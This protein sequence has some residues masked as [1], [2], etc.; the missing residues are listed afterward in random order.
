MIHQ[1]HRILDRPGAVAVLHGRPLDH[2]DGQA[3]MAGGGDFCRGGLATG[4]LADDDVDAMIPQE[5]DFRL[6]REG[7]PRKQVADIG[8]I[9]R[10]IDGIDAAHEIVMLR[11]GVEGLRLLTTD[12][13]EDPARFHAQC[14]HGLVH[15]RNAAPAI[16]CLLV[17]AEPF[18]PQ[19][20]NAGRG[21]RSTGIGGYLPGKGVG[22]V[23]HEIDA[24]ATQIGSKPRRTA[25]A[26]GAHRRG[27]R[28]G[29]ERAAG[30]RQSDG[31]IG[32]T[33]KARRKVAGL[34]RAAQYED[35]SFV[36][37]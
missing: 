14:R 20:R 4:I 25:E 35:A 28:R 36:H 26:A 24:L 29:I 5:R 13:K 19:Q 32:P 22:C 10:R 9:E 30:Q 17:P 11:G 37:A 31:Q 34:A 12:G 21:A 16:A 15:A 8:R 2:H 18:Q 33:G 6:G 23:D 27:L 1:P 7:A 3:E